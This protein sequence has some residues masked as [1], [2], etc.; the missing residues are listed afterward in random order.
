MNPKLDLMFNLLHLHIF[1]SNCQFD[2]F[3]WMSN[4]Q[5]K[6]NK[7]ETELLIHPY[8]PPKSSIIS[9]DGIVI[10]PVTQF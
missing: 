9:V 10:H 2:I 6:F 7:N 4:R 3:I 8:L 5:V 1:I